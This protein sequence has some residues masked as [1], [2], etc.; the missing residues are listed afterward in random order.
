MNEQEIKVPRKAILIGALLFAV[1]FWL[2]VS[3]I[4]RGIEPGHLRELVRSGDWRFFLLGIGCM[5]V[6]AFMEGLNFW[7]ILRIAGYPH[8]VLQC[9]RYAATGIFFNAITPSASGGQPMQILA[10]RSD[11]IRI[12]H[13]TFAI[14]NNLLGYQ[15][16]AV[17]FSVTGLILNRDVLLH[18]TDGLAWILAV[19]ILSNALLA[20]GIA[21]FIFFPQTTG[22]LAG[23]G[24]KVIGKVFPTFGRMLSAKLGGFTSEYG[25]CAAFI[26]SHPAGLLNTILISLV[27]VSA[28][29]AVPYFAYR[30][31]GVGEV[32]FTELFLLQAV[33]FVG[34]GLIPLPGAMGVNEIL[35]LAVYQNL[36]SEEMVSD[37]TFIS[38]T[39]SLYLWIAVYGMM[40]VIWAVRL[41]RKRLPERQ[42]EK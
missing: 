18:H 1:L 4:F 36:F 27:Q 25:D 40:V 14:F 8:T 19:G 15:I 22:K 21:G 3:K 29:F 38:R 11:G 26:R 7:R 10:M 42:G 32:S 6:Y 17:A 16:S 5:L 23:G 30:F 2:T 39:I 28:M 33:I 24:I 12:S 35:T 37:G 13:G 41:W 34:V 31:L 9:F 20:A